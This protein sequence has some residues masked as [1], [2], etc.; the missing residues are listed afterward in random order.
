MRGR[1]SRQCV[2]F[3]QIGY[4]KNKGVRLGLTFAVTPLLGHK[5]D[6]VLAGLIVIILFS[7]LWAMLS[8]LLGR[9]FPWMT[10]VLGILIG[11]VIRRAG[12]GLDWR[13]PTLAAAGTLAGALVSNVVVAAA[14]TAEELGGPGVH[15]QSGVCDLVT[16]DELGSLRTALRLLGY[17]PDN[18][19]SQAP[20]H[21][22]SDPVDRHTDDDPEEFTNC[23]TEAATPYA[24]RDLRWSADLLVY[25]RED[26][27]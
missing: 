4:L 16:G 1:Y 26:G 6:A 24:V 23:V 9:I 20:F 11:H 19:H 17:L 3:F 2:P 21:P 25:S 15:G 12:R 5:S 7:V 27:P 14:F 13:F 8:T 22:T 18:N 10:I